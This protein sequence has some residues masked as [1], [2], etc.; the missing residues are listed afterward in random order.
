MAI[1][2]SPALYAV[3]LRLS[4]RYGLSWYDSL[5]V[6]AAL[7]AQSAPCIVNTSSTDSSSGT[8]GSRTPFL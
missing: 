6:A 2:S 1:H 7:E 5:V 8:S 4:D 3:A